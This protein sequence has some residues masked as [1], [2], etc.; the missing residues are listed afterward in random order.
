MIDGIEK[1]P[2]ERIRACRGPATDVPRI[3]R[4]LMSPDPD[5]RD[6]AVNG[7]LWDRL[8]H[9]YTLYPASAFAVPFL[10]EMLRMD[11]IPGE[12]VRGDVLAYLAICAQAEPQEAAWGRASVLHGGWAQ[13]PRPPLR[14]L[15]EAGREVYRRFESHPKSRLSNPARELIAFCRR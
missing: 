4:G 15:L 13:P 11:A 1:V 7:G 14:E 10:V 12:D 3:L 5:V 6:E 8:C 2:W 9:Q